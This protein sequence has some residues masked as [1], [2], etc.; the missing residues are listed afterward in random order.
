MRLKP[1]L[2]NQFKNLNNLI[3]KKLRDSSRVVQREYSKPSD[4][5]H[6][7]LKID[8]EKSVRTVLLRFLIN[9]RPLRQIWRP[10]AFFSSHS[11]VSTAKSNQWKNSTTYSCINGLSES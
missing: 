9:R 5:F 4:I 11:L 2:Y 3:N 6:F 8:I 1:E 7:N 10:E